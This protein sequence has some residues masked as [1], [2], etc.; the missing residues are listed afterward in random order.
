MPAIYTVETIQFRH[1]HWTNSVKY[2]QMYP[3]NQ[4]TARD[5]TPKKYKA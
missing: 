1:C 2:G 3:I 4:R 5:T